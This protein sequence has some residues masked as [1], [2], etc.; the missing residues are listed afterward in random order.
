MNEVCNNVNTDGTNL[1]KLKT[2]EI[3]KDVCHYF[4]KNKS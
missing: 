1:I 3:N 2:Y 4:T